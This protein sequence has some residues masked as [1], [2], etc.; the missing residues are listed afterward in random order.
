MSEKLSS[1]KYNPIQTN[2]KN[3]LA[4]LFYFYSKTHALYFD[5]VRVAIRNSMLFIIQFY[6]MNF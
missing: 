5:Y 6:D 2:K 4:K 1:G 3:N